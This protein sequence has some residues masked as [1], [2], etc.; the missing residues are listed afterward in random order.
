[1]KTTV[2]R[3]ALKPDRP[4][5]ETRNQKTIVQMAASDQESSKSGAASDC[6]HPVY[7]WW[8]IMVFTHPWVVDAAGRFSYIV[9]AVTNLLALTPKIRSLATAA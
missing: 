2:Y 3:R 8:P 5:H 6:G 9:F 4:E 1:M 7:Y